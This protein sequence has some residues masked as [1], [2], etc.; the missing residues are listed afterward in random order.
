MTGLSICIY[1]RYSTEKQDARSIE[2]QVRR[3]RAF[4]ATHGH[5]VVAV[6]ADEAISGAHLVRKGLTSMLADAKLR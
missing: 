4:A 5:D 1:A 2:D 6:Y 3:C